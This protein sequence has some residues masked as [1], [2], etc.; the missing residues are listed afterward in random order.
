MPEEIL[1]DEERAALAASLGPLSVVPGRAPPLPIEGP[2]PEPPDPNDPHNQFMAPPEP[3][4]PPDPNDPHNQ[5]MAA[6]EAPV[7]PPVAPPKAPPPPS[8]PILAT[9][10]PGESKVVSTKPDWYEPL[11]P[12]K[13]SPIPGVVGGLGLGLLGALLAR[14]NP[15]VAAGMA[16]L[17][18]LSA[19][20]SLADAPQREFDN[21]TTAA[22]RQAA[23]H[24]KL[25][26]GG[27]DST[28]ELGRLELARK[29]FEAQQIEDARKLAEDTQLNLMD[30]PETRKERQIAF[31]LSQGRP[32]GLTMDQLNKMNGADIRRWRT[33]LQQLA[34]QARGADFG[35]EA[36]NRRTET[37]FEQSILANAEHDRREGIEEEMQVG[38]EGREQ[39]KLDE[40]SEIPG[41]AFTG[42]RAPNV[43]SVEKARLLADS[44]EV[45]EMAANNMVALWKKLDTKARVSPAWLEGA[46]S[47]ED[48]GAVNEL[49]TWG[50]TLDT[51]QRSLAN[52]GVPQQFEMEIMR[53]V[54]PDATGIRALLNNGQAWA[55][56]GR[57]LGQLADTRMRKYGYSRQGAPAPVQAP[58]SGDKPLKEKLR[59]AG[60]A[61]KGLT[62]DVVGAAGQVVQNA[63]DT[64]N[65][66]APGAAPAIKKFVVQVRN[67]AGTAYEAAIEV[68]QQQLDAARA[69]AKANGLPDDTIKVVP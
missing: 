55:A 42:K 63:T 20:Q 15:G 43:A 52:M 5:F 38:K 36:H 39:V 53:T 8:A 49:R 40:Q 12:P 25:N 24:A 14:K 32:D 31:D 67:K 29:K 69:R 35:K 26:G 33:G 58:S 28:G 59:E 2:L 51:A 34:G 37:Q 46:L 19:M 48:R 64:V 47:D 45:A 13:T 3:E 6:P 4:L 62:Q 41:Y 30:S 21:R 17:G 18:G 9:A 44:T 1:T 23:M 10:A 57:V 60:E 11:A 7:A 50:L 16:G 66:V 68:T 22:E 65:Q 27:G 56:Q 61:T 54:S